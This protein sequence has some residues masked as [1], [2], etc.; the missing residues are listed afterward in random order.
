M[1][2]VKQ[3]SSELGQRLLA[4]AQQECHWLVQV[5]DDVQHTLTTEQVVDA[6]NDC[7][8][9]PETYVWT[10]G[11]DSWQQLQLVD[12]LVDALHARA[13]QAAQADRPSSTLN[14]AQQAVER[15]PQL[16]WP[17]LSQPQSS[18]PR[19]P[20]LPSNGSARNDDSAIFSLTM[21]VGDSEPPEPSERCSEDSGLIDLAAMA[22]SAA[23]KQPA[24]DPSMDALLVG[25][26]FPAAAVAPVATVTPEPAPA[27]R[28]NKG[29]IMGLIAAITLLSAMLVFQVVRTGETASSA[30]ASGATATP[31]KSAAV[32]ARAPAT[33]SSGAPTIAAPEPPTPASSA[34]A[35]PAPSATPDNRIAASPQP[36]PI[37][38]PTP[39]APPSNTTRPPKKDCNSLCKQG[40][41]TCNMR[42]AVNR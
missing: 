34:S 25:G 29:I 30:P 1:S 20:E 2:S 21:L 6:Y 23:A 26:L 8:V 41:L 5:S 15:P 32:A 7:V 19:Q 39:P 28:G 40:D 42:C 10:Q 33:P 13:D 14:Q 27:P 4:A 36:T 35:E 17:H 37:K 16:F 38:Q 3:S 22:A 24:P 11:M 12:A 18:Q 9:D 31:A